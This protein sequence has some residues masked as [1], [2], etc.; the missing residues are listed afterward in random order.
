MKYV[1]FHNIKFKMPEYQLLIGLE[2]SYK[3]W[4][5]AQ[6]VNIY[7]ILKA[8]IWF[9]PFSLVYGL[10]AF[11]NVDNYG[12]PLNKLNNGYISRLIWLQM[13]SHHWSSVI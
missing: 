6:N 12:L 5:K 9:Y 2:P 13:S 4:Q 8:Y 7:S 11:E 1:Q 10:Y 3:N